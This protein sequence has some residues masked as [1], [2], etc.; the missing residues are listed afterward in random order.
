MSK[1]SGK[2]NARKCGN[3]GRTGHNRKTCKYKTKVAK[4]SR[5]KGP[6]FTEIEI[7]AMIERAVKKAMKEIE[8]EKKNPY[9]QLKE[10]TCPYC[11]GKGKVSDHWYPKG[12]KQW[13]GHPHYE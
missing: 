3:C 5:N 4:K 9:T 11:K 8:S 1:K 6:L 7:E 13:D 10:R 2:K 12:L